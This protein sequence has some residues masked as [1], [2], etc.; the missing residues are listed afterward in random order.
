MGIFRGG[1]LVVLV[2]EQIQ[3]VLYNQTSSNPDRAGCL[4]H[5]ALGTGTAPLATSLTARPGSHGA[6]AED[7]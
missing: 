5:H 6:A 1:V 3:E 7:G 2:Q 4:C